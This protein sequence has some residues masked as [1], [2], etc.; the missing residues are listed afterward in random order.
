MPRQRPPEQLDIPLVWE[1]EESPARPGPDGI[2]PAAGPAQPCGIGRLALASLADLGV[3]SLAVGAALA[4]AAAF[5]AGLGAGQF[6]LAAAAGG[7]LATVVAVGCLWGWRATPGLLLVDVRA[8]QPLALARA[9]V[10][11]LAWLATSPVVAVPLLIG[12]RG[13]R[14]VERLAGSAFNCR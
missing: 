11:W 14:P 13:R 4:V 8:D 2:P 7:E 10:L 9:T 1:V 12:R 5:G 3:T 6:L